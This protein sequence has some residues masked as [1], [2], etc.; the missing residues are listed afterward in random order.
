[1][2]PRCSIWWG[3]N[4]HCLQRCDNV[5]HYSTTTTV[6]RFG[7]K[8]GKK[9][10]KAAQEIKGGCNHRECILLLLTDA[11]DAHDDRLKAY[12]IQRGIESRKKQVLRSDGSL[13]IYRGSRTIAFSPGMSDLMLLLLWFYSILADLV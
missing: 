1:M 5:I 7:E 10:E 3:I 13:S 2:N 8:K 12:S 6:S 11:H 9:R 4:F